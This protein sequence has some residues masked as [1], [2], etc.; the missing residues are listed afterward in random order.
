MMPSRDPEWRRFVNAEWRKNNRAAVNLTH[1][2]DQTIGVVEARRILGLPTPPKRKPINAPEDPRP[3]WERHGVSK[4][5]YY[6]SLIKKHGVRCPE[7]NGSGKVLRE[8][9]TS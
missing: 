2:M 9:G 8:R 7:C 4:K 6:S 3:P 1:K 5:K